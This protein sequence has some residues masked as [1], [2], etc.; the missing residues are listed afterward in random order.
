MAYSYGMSGSDHL[1]RVPFNDVGI[2]SGDR[3]SC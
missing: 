3:T 2:L 1:S